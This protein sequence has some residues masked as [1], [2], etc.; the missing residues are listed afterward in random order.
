ML[1][2]QFLV[3]FIISITYELMKFCRTD[4]TLTLYGHSTH[5]ANRVFYFVGTEIH[6]THNA[7][8]V[9]YKLWKQFHGQPLLHV[10]VRCTASVIITATSVTCRNAS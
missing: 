2:M 1:L 5:N 3:Q 8:R 10:V 4:L 9:F 7:N 6:S